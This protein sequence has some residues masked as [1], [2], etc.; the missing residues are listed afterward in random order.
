VIGIKAEVPIKTIGNSGFTQGM[1]GKQKAAIIAAVIYWFDG[2]CKAYQLIYSSHV[3][4][5]S[6]F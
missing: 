3:L 4:V 1:S 5:I 2:H 6:K